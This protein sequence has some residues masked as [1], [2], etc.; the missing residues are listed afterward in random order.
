MA[1]GCKAAARL[2]RLSPDYN[3]IIVERR[4]FVSFGNCGLPLYASGDVDDLFDLAR[5]SYGVVRDEKYFGDVK[6]VKVFVRTEATTINKGKNEVVC[7]NIDKDKTFILRYD[8]LII[9]TGTEPKKPPFPYPSSPVVSSFHSP[10]DFRDFR[11]AVQ[12]GKVDKAIII[13]GGF[14]GCEMVEA[15]TTLWGIETTLI[16]KEKS[17]LPGCLDT[18]MAYYL[19]SCIKQDKINLMLSSSINKIEI[20]ENEKPVVLLDGDQKVISD[21][22]FYCLGVKPDSNLA[23]KSGIKTGRYGGIIVDEKMKTSQPGIWAAGDCVEAKN[24]VTGSS[25]YFSFGSLANRMGRVAADV[26]A[27]KKTS[28]NGAAGTFSL[29]LFDNIIGA[30]GLTEEKAKKCEIDAASVIGCWSDRP[31]Y[32]PDAKNLFGKLVYEKRTLKLLGLQ[33]IGEGEVT[34]YID[35]FS[36][37]LS[38]KKTIEDLLNVEHCYTP[39]HS[40]PISPLNNLGYMVL[41][42]EAGKIKNVNPLM[43]PAFS[44]YFIDVREPY[45]IDSNPFSEKC[46]LIP[47]SELRSKLNSWKLEQPVMFVCEKGPRS[48]EAARIFMNHGCKNISYL[49]GGNL[50]YS[51]IKNYCTES[52][53]FNSEEV[54]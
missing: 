33:M 1:A 24:F 36:E 34:R 9:A 13:G 44:G 23:V 18:E 7:R 35:V 28:F 52:L 42:Q 17:L 16:E 49:G 11:Q 21:Y 14:I 50:L 4:S 37:L 46:L 29:K 53:T 39:A 6:N 10:A 15:L 19:E 30:T 20:D 27:G 40:S 8:K 31:E 47:L 3:I 48:Y 32:H 43:V 51:R 2:S 54:V 25:D 38:Q 22:V 41:N 26:I 5:T 12:Q 45:E